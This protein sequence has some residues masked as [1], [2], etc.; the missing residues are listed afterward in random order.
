E[1]EFTRPV[2]ACRSERAADAAALSRRMDRQHPELALVGT[3]DLPPRASRRTERDGAHDRPG[4]IDRDKQFSL[5]KPP[6]RVAQLRN[7]AI[8][9][10][11]LGLVGGHGDFS[12][13]G[14]LAWQRRSDVKL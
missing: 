12:G 14:Q 5:T 1:A 7:V 9:G 2:E 8:G 4:R 11:S 3:G 6:A 10:H 13:C